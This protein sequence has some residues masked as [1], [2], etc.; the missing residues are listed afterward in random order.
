MPT[1]IPYIFHLKSIYCTTTKFGSAI[2]QLF[3]MAALAAALPESLAV[4]LATVAL[5]AAR[6]FYIL[7][8]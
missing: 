6:P 1:I 5:V 2:T 7:T 3:N 8:L 4:A